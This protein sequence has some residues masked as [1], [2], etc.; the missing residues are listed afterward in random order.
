[1]MRILIVEDDIDLGRLLVNCLKKEDYHTIHVENGI[2]GLEKMKEIK[3]DLI[4]LDIMLPE[5]DGFSVIENI[6]EISSIPVLMLTAK[7]EEKDK[8]KGLK[9]GADDYLTKPFG[10]D[11]F[12]ARVNSIIRRANYYNQDPEKGIIKYGNIELNNYYRTLKVNLREIP[13]SN[14]E[15]DLL[16]LLMTN[17]NHIFTKEQL[18]DQIWGLEEYDSYDEKNMVSFIS[19]LRKKI[20]MDEEEYGGFIETVY[21]LGYR[22]RIK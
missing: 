9:L 15:F 7:S 17:E 5:V 8:V 4:I 11:E 16:L 3:F 2:L 12:L 19:K 13:L 1:M 10:I 22:W 14:K 6:R 20:F 18:Y 21:G